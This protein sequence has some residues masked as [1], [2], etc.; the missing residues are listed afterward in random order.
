MDPVEYVLTENLYRRHLTQGQKG[1]VAVRA[2]D[3]HMAEAKERQRAAGGDKKSVEYKQQAT[4]PGVKQDS[5]P[6]LKVPYTMCTKCSD[7]FTG[8]HKFWHCPVC[9]YHNEMS[10]KECQDCH[11]WQHKG[12]PDTFITRKSV[13]LDDDAKPAEKA[14]KEKSVSAPVHQAEKPAFE[15]RAASQAGKAV[16]V[17]GRSVAAAKFIMD[18]GTE[19]EIKA[20]ESGK[21][22]LKPVEQQV[23]ARVR[24]QP[25]VAAVVAEVA[26]K[27]KAVA[28]PTF[29]ATNDS[30]EWAKWTWNPVTGCKHDCRYCYARD[31]AKRQPLSAAARLDAPRIDS[32]LSTKALILS[33][34]RSLVH[35]SVCASTVSTLSS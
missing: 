9:H 22:G 31:L 32:P 7:W 14:E 25:E 13:L 15:R 1:M 2:L 27:P 23:R 34:T 35:F 18:H 4:L 28:K 30:I 21:A 12:G 20:V 10:D 17:S 5:T 19:E 26:A 8:E 6:P 16:G 3:Y 29:N 11:D 24:Q 33:K